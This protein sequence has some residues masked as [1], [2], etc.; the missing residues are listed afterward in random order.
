MIIYQNIYKPCPT[1]KNKLLHDGNPQYSSELLERIIGINDYDI[2][3]L[4]YLE[5]NG[6]IVTQSDPTAKANSCPGYIL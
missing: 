3:S 4:E 1:Q 2:L 5:E 6:F